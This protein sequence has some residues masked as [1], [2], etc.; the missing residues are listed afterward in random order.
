MI[1]PQALVDTMIGRT[2]TA[3]A[4]HDGNYGPEVV[5]ITLDDGRHIR[6][7]GWGYDEWGLDITNG[8]DA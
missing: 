3:A 5:D 7:R 1:E 4:V 2:I 6:F 8:T